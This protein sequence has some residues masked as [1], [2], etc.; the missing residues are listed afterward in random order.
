MLRIE[1]RGTPYQRGQQQGEATRDLALPWINRRIDE[2]EQRYTAPSRNAL[3]AQIGPLM[4]V[5]RQEE[6]KNYP[7]AIAECAGL[8]AGLGLD[9]ELY[10][11][12][13]FYHRLGN[14]LPQCTVVG[15]RDHQGRPLLGKSDDIGEQELGMNILETTTPDT[16]YAHRHFH[17]AGTIWTVAGGNE[18]GLCIG[19]TGIPGPLR[20]DGL[21]S[22]TALHSILPACADIE[23]AIAH[24]RTLE[25]N[26]YGFS[27]ILG[28]AEGGLALIEKTSA[29]MVVLDQAAIPLAH[30][31]HI[32]DQEFA[33]Q[34]PEQHATIH[35]NGV[36]RL[37][38]AQNLLA[39]G[40]L[41]Q[42][43]LRNR[44]P[45]GA[46]C[47]RGEGDLHTDFAVVFAPMEKRMHLWPGYPD[48]VAMETLDL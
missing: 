43:I 26:A 8:A 21:F 31:N 28:D 48:E 41:P 10:F 38:T 5:W 1:T 19:M 37:K 25:L 17:F 12:L 27:L 24:I 47:Q 23:Q 9:Q 40:A 18:C 33:A 15:S 11:A 44:D 16:G 2:L 4:S 46:I 35:H 29:G 3:L 22:L 30:T 13:K 14:H 36:Q 45:A 7:Q 34:N 39:S 42:D 32:L 6:E 20:D